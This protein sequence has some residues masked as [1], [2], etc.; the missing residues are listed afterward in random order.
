MKQTKLEDKIAHC[1]Y[2]ALREVTAGM[3]TIV[4]WEEYSFYPKGEGKSE[5]IQN[6]GSSTN[7]R[8]EVE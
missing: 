2:N 3:S 1:C 4:E 5:L 8:S 7:I 6:E